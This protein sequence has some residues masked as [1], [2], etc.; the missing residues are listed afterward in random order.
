MTFAIY[1][2]PS[3]LGFS[4]LFSKEAYDSLPKVGKTLDLIFGCDPKAE[5]E[6]GDDK[7]GNQNEIFAATH[8]GFEDLVVVSQFNVITFANWKII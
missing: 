8:S 6:S 2:G 3:L 4:L 5:R 7:D 1:V